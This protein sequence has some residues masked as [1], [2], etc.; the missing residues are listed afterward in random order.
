MNS[1]EI[2]KKRQSTLTK[3]AIVGGVSG[4][5]LAGFRTSDAK[6]IALYAVIGVGVSILVTQLFILPKIYPFEK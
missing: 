5:L 3:A 1:E 4:L 6:K 2:Y